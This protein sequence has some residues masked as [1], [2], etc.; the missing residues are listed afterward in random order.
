M[1]SR[2]S[3]AL[4]DLYKRED[5]LS[6]VEYAV[7][8]ALLVVGCI[9]AWTT[10]SNGS[11]KPRTFT[12]TFS[13]GSDRSCPE[14]K[15]TVSRS[16]KRSKITD[17]EVGNTNGTNA[18]QDANVN[19]GNPDSRKNAT[20]IETKKGNSEASSG[21]GTSGDAP[22]ATDAAGNDAKKPNGDKT[23]SEDD[24]RQ[25]LAN[26]LK[27]YPRSFPM[28]T[29]SIQTAPVVHRADYIE[30]D[31]FRCYLQKRRF[32]YG[33]SP[34]GSGQAGTEKSGVFYQDENGRWAGKFTTFAQ[35]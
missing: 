27:A 29:L 26:L 20:T 28:S 31:L 11:T 21:P 15:E 30:I 14:P 1:F 33:V 19:N 3:Q 32:A 16:P 23:M 4:A 34:A 24:A 9:V 25:A 6:K 35:K 7:M 2:F 17:T 5:G 13:N 22:V 10:S 8:L 12:V 18:N